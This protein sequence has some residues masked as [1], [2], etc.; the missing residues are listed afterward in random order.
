MVS[1]DGVGKESETEARR[2]GSTGV[3]SKREGGD[4]E[5]A[6]FAIALKV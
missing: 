1:R 3:M 2:G 6:R 4:Q 5:E